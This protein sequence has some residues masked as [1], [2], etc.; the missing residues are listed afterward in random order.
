MN[1]NPVDGRPSRASTMVTQDS[2]DTH[3][4][5][6]PIMANEIVD[7]LSLRALHESLFVALKSGAPPW[8]VAA[9][10]QPEE[11]GDLS[12]A[13]RR[14]MPAMMRGADARYLTLTRRQIDTIRQLAE[15]SG[16]ERPTNPVAAR[17]RTAR[18][19]ALRYRGDGNPPVSHPSSAIS[20]CFPGLEFDA[21]NM[22]RRIFVGVVLTEHNNFVEDVEDPQFADLKGCRL[23]AIQSGEPTPTMTQA[24]GP[25]FPRGDPTEILGTAESPAAVAFKEWSNTIALF[26]ES[27]GKLVSCIFTE[28]PSDNEVFY[29]PSDKTLK[30]KVR[31]LEVRRIFEPADDG[32]ADSKAVLTRALA[33]AGELSQGLC[34]PWQNDYRECACYYWAASRPDYVNVEPDGQGGS[35]GDMWL[36]RKL[37]GEYVPDTRTDELVFNYDDLFSAWEKHLR[38]VIDGR[39]AD[40]PHAS[41]TPKSAPTS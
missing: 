31:E 19:A 28:Q 4:L 3:R 39:A 34:S 10:R 22:W 32:G 20:N 40:I 7:N 1:G 37:S 21:R 30:T 36:Q 14:K 29:D 11:I 24:R 6:A 35:R 41:P 26:L 25:A 17:N 9:L 8:F 38:F 16:F 18:I 23:L 5:F 13:A 27:Q 2:N 12:D 15:P 33:Q